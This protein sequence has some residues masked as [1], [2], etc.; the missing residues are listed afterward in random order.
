MAERKAEK[1]QPKPQ[2]QVPIT[3]SITENKSRGTGFKKALLVLGT[4][5]ILTLTHRMAY[6]SGINK[7]KK[8]ISPT[9]DKVTQNVEAAGNVPTP[10]TFQCVTPTPAECT[11][12]DIKY[13][14]SQYPTFTWK[15]LDGKWKTWYTKG[16][17]QTLDELCIQKNGEYIY[18]PPKPKVKVVPTSA[19]AAE[20][21]K[22]EVKQ[23][24]NINV[25]QQQQQQIIIEEKKEAPK[26]EPSEHKDRYVPDPQNPNVMKDLKPT[27]IP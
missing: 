26:E 5:G 17:N 24:T 22:I 18:I 11:P 3:G 4:A 14:P 21:P 25:Q 8:P 1:N 20:Q 9:P 16:E 7:N 2:D 19:P 23:E 15:D 6:E 13:G 10:T 27:D 12:K